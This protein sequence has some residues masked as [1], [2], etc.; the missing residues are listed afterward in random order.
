MEPKLLKILIFN[1]LIFSNLG[2]VFSQRNKYVKS[3]DSK[4][5]KHVTEAGWAAFVDDFTVKP[6]DLFQKQPKA[7]GLE[8]GFTMKLNSEKPGFNGYKHYRFQEYFEN[9]PIENG[10]YLIHAQND[11]LKSGNGQIFSAKAIQKSVK[12]DLNTAISNCIK[13]I[14]A[15]T[16][17]WQVP[18]KEAKIK[19]KKNDSKATYFPKDEKVYVFD[20][21]NESIRLC[22][23]LTIQSPE[24]GKSFICFVDTES[25]QIHKKTAM[26]MLCDPTTVNTTWYG[27]QNISTSHNLAGTYFMENDC[28]PFVFG[29]YDYAFGT[30]D[31]IRNVVN[32]TSWSTT[33]RYQTAGTSIW[34]M[35]QTYNAYKNVFNR[36]GHSGSNSDIDIYQDYLFPP[37]LGGTNNASYSYDPGGDDEIKIGAGPTDAINDNYNALD[38][39]GH[40]FTHGVDYYEGNLAYEKESGALDESFADIFGEWVESQFR[41]PDWLV[42]ADRIVNGAAASMRS[43]VNPLILGNPNMYLGQNW[44]PTTGN[45]PG[46]NWGVHNNSG[47]QN[48]MFYL[49]TIGGSG[50][51]NGQTAQAPVGSGYFYTVSGIGMAKSI[52]IAYHVLTNFMHANS[53]YYEARNAWVQAATEIYGECSFEAIQTGKAWDAAGI[54][55]PLAYI[56]NGATVC[57]NPPSYLSRLGQIDVGLNCVVTATASNTP[58]QL[59]SGTK[60]VFGSQFKALAGSNLRAYISDDC[61]YG[62]Y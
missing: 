38:I 58:S 5:F 26:D 52:R 31:L 24:F 44:T 42:G 62:K 33:P 21:S 11:K 60:I 43:F 8:K 50:W 18:E 9:I 14:G 32:N 13:Q 48:Q 29:V 2:N 61:K 57:G 35:Q 41:T 39:I 56:I 16:Y 6:T 23:K 12:I 1:L 15:K 55:P 28:T 4:V 19:I 59:I 54:G 46:D 3:F 47:A 20:E 40:E 45:D 51:N 30:G 36:D 27:M 34:T 22:Y 37:E 7:F 49:L 25:G 17:N 10:N 53:T